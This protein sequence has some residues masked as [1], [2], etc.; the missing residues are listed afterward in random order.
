M[1]RRVPVWWPR[2]RKIFWVLVAV[3]LAWPT[4]ASSKRSYDYDAPYDLPVVAIPEGRGIEHFFGTWGAL[5]S[6]ELGLS[7]AMTIAPRRILHAHYS[8]T[9][10]KYYKVLR[11]TGEYAI[12]VVHYENP[13]RE[14][15]ATVF[16]LLTLRRDPKDGETLLFMGHRTDFRMIDQP[17]NR[18]REYFLDLLDNPD[19]RVLPPTSGPWGAWAFYVYRPYGKGR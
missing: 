19:K 1:G 18:P 9:Y 11:V 7:G 14:G 17:L 2:G 3:L 10:D 5:D 15:S 13:V 8:A 4:A 12:L 6:Q 16:Y